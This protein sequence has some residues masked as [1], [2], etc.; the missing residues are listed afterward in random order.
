M[1]IRVFLPCLPVLYFV[2]F[3][4]L[5]YVINFTAM[6]F[7]RIQSTKQKTIPPP[8]SKY[9]NPTVQ[10]AMALLIAYVAAAIGAATPVYQSFIIDDTAPIP[11]FTTAG[12]EAGLM[13]DM[14]LLFKTTTIN[15]PGSP[16]RDKWGWHWFKEPLFLARLRDLGASAHGSLPLAMRLGGGQQCCTIYNVTGKLQFPLPTAPYYC[17]VDHKTPTHII[18]QEIW[19][20]ILAALHQANISLVFGITGGFGRQAT[21]GTRGNRW[22]P[23]VSGFVELLNYTLRRLARTR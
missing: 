21:N 14:D 23:A 13:F 4:F 1:F 16:P 10:T 19:D 9:R 12:A 2:I 3:G 8:T 18:T 20:A 17:S 15:T 11:I 7:C 22:D 6:R 5:N